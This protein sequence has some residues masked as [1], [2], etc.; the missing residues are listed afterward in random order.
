[1]LIPLIQVE[2][3]A[4]WFLRRRR[5]AESLAGFI[6][7]VPAVLVGDGL[8]V[9]SVLVATFLEYGEND[10][11]RFAV[12]PLIWLLFAGLTARLIGEFAASRGAG[13]A[14]PAPN[15]PRQEAMA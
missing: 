14:G 13:A 6:R 3:L 5:R 1:L 12:E 11:F 7:T 10:R 2:M 9:Y 8:L 15:P 4:L